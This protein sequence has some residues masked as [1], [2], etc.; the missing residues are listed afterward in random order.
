M[1]TVLKLTL[2]LLFLTGFTTNAQEK[3]ITLQELPATAQ[4]FISKN[5]PNQAASY[6]IEDKGMISTDYDVMLTGG[7][8]IEFDGKGNWKEIDGNKS[9]IPNT[10]LPVGI[11]SYIDANY[12]GQGVE[13][14]DREYNGYNVELLNNMELEFDSNGKFLRI[15]D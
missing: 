4:A 3:K 1:K 10:V 11:A 7:T 9:A 5:F 15:D 13:K 2:A 12:K 6:V 14:I 8:E